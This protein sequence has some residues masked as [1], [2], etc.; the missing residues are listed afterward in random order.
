M[1]NIERERSNAETLDFWYKGNY[2]VSRKRVLQIAALTYELG[3]RT[4]SCGFSLMRL[5]SETRL[6]KVQ[7]KRVEEA[8]FFI[9]LFQVA[10]NSC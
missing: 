4:G 2:E 3:I 6:H 5:S 8:I 10:K 1:L 7:G 9:L